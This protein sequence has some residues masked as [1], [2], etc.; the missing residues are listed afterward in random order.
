M[1]HEVPSAAHPG[2]GTAKTIRGS[3]G[4]VVEVAAVAGPMPV[5]PAAAGA[6]DSPWQAEVPAADLDASDTSLAAPPEAAAAAELPIRHSEPAAVVAQPPT[7]A[8]LQADMQ[9]QALTP[10]A[11]AAAAAP[12]T[13]AAPPSPPDGVK[14]A[15]P[16]PP[17][18]APLPAD[19]KLAPDLP[20]APPLPQKSASKAPAPPPPPPPPGGRAPPRPPLPPPPPG[21]KGPPRPPAPP[22]PPPPPAKAVKT[23]RSQAEAAPGDALATTGASTPAMVKITSPAGDQGFTAGTPEP[24]DAVAQPKSQPKFRI[25]HWT[26]VNHPEPAMIRVTCGQVIQRVKPPDPCASASR[27]H[28]GG[29]LFG[30]NC[31]R[32]CRH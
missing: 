7:H 22:P 32:L 14:A 13:S 27:C 12:T 4:P 29:A 5:A 11:P 6:P 26:K 18:Q 3:A 30:R 1:D 25:L 9:Q 20:P 31:Q 2:K 21:G 16:H 8:E 28:G 23:A 17:Q 24:D 15:P 10:P 19:I